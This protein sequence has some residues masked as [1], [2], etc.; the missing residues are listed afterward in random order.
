MQNA[1]ETGEGPSKLEDLAT[2]GRR[3]LTIEETAKCLGVSRRICY[4]A[5][6]IGQIPTIH[7]GRRILVPIAALDR[8]LE[9]QAS[10][11]AA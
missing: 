8:M 2:A 1:I 6:R 9:E 3:T 5:A 7:I 10:K 11:V 4:E